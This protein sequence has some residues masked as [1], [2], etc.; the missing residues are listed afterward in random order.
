MFG[1]E[2]KWKRKNVKIVYIMKKRREYVAV[3][4]VM[5]LQILHIKNLFV[6]GMSLKNEKFVFLVFAKMGIDLIL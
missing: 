4:I 6:N 2:E 3:L 1:D 5:K